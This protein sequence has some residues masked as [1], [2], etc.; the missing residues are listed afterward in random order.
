MGSSSGKLGISTRWGMNLLAGLAVVMGLYFGSAIFIPFVFAAI[1]ASVIWP[2]ANWLHHKLHFGWTFSCLLVVG[3]LVTLNLVITANL[4][5][6]FPK[7]F[8]TSPTY[9]LKKVRNAS[10]TW[11][12][13][14]PTW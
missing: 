1:L 7:S 11:C 14:V 12:A 8:R 9:A 5:F 4:C 13:N 3:G 10:T 2:A 6:P